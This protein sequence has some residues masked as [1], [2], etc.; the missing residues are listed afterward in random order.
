MFYSRCQNVR[1]ST[2][3]ES[4]TPSWAGTD[5]YD[6][7][8]LSHIKKINSKGYKGNSKLFTHK[9]VTLNLEY[10]VDFGSLRSLGRTS[11]FIRRYT[12]LRPSNAQS[13][14]LLTTNP[15]DALRSIFMGEQVEQHEP[16]GSPSS[17]LFEPQVNDYVVVKLLAQRSVK[18]YIAVI[19]SKAEDEFV[20]KFMRKSLGNKFTFPATD[21]VANIDQDDIAEILSQPSVN[22]RQQYTFSLDISKYKNFG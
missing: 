8:I 3:K 7:V 21:D 17:T 10:I 4:I 18:H 13:S 15:A 9:D 11:E 1:Q 19:M 12:E 16:A 5:F 22:N 6:E 20:A 14:A 2:T